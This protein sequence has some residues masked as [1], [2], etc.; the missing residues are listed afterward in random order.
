[1]DNVN[2]PSHYAEK[3]IEVIN[4]IQDTLPQD[5][6]ID[7]CIRSAIKYVSIWCKKNGVEDSKKAAV[8]LEWAVSRAVDMVGKKEG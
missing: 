8:Y 7:Y 1:M 3:A 6:F 5:R 2:H 4:Y